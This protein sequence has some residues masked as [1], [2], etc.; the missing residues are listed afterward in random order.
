LKILTIIGGQSEN[1]IG[2]SREGGSQ[3]LQ[4][5]KSNTGK[6]G[7]AAKNPGLVGG[8][9]FTTN[10]LIGGDGRPQTMG[11]GG[12]ERDTNATLAIRKNT[13]T[14]IR[15]MILQEKRGGGGT[16]KGVEKGGGGGPEEVMESAKLGKE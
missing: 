14:R 1:A 3:I 16:R 10:V 9:K 4:N 2:L 11:K 15:K 5:E 8:K 7:G 6:E 12:Q 13:W